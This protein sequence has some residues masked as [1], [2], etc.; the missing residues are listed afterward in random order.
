[1]LASKNKYFC[2]PLQNHSPVKK[3]SGKHRKKR[4]PQESFFSFEPPK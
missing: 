4:N 2:D 3:S 1:M